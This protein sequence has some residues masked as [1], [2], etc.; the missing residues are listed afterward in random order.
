MNGEEILIFGVPLVV[1]G[2]TVFLAHWLGKLRSGVALS[3]LGLIWTGFTVMLFFGM[4]QGNGW[5]YLF[6]LVLL[7][8]PSGAGLGLGSLIGWIRSEPKLA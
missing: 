7:S 2:V 6:A 5:D 1:F 8:A 4:E 3:V